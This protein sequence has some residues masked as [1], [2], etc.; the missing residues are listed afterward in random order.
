LVQTR[1]QIFQTHN[2]TD[3]QDPGNGRHTSATRGAFVISAFQLNPLVS[4][5]SRLEWFA[6]PH[7]IRAIVAGQYGEATVGVTVN[8]NSWFDI[9]PEIRADFAGQPSFGEANSK[10]LR[11]NQ[12]SLAVE[13]VIK[14]RIF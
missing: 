13:L 9:R 3:A 2:S 11:Q 14:T 7:G 8:P 4:L 6:D 12:I 5:H 1:Y 10:V